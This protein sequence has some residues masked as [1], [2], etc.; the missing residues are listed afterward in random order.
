MIFKAISLA[1]VALSLSLPL[2]GQD[3]GTNVELRMLAFS[4]PLQQKEAFV[5]DSAPTSSASGILAPIKG[6]LNQQFTP[7]LLKS[8][9]VIIT[10][11]QDRESMNRDG[12]LIGEVTLPNSVNSA[13]LLF[14]PGKPGEKARC[15]VMA[16][17]DTKKAFP[18]GTYHVTNLSPLPIRL[19]LGKKPHDFKPG[20]VTIIEDL[21]I[22]DGMQF[23]MHALIL[24]GNS[25]KEISSSI[26]P[27]PGKRRSVL[28][29]FQNPLNGDVQLKGF[30]DSAPR[31][32]VEVTAGQ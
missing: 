14:L 28:V 20:Q 9:R 17:H 15:Q 1:A 22:E 19:V 12:E 29:M 32:T 23:G 26:W 24:K 30:D 31:E 7:V 6:Y 16:I 18:G 21:P 13:I 11:K 2:S 8:R 25:W 5:H 27:H 4:S 10:T 3:G